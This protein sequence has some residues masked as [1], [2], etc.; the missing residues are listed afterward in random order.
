MATIGVGIIGAGQI[1][2]L[3]AK[4][5]LADERAQIRAVCDFKEHTAIE[6][7]MA[8][9]ADAYYTDHRALLEDRNVQLVDITTP[10]NLH[11][12]MVL[13]A[14][15]A[16]K[17]VLVQRPLALTVAEAD[18]LI[19]EAQK[20]G[21]VLAV[22][23]PN[24]QYGPLVDAKGYLDS[25]EIGDPISLRCKVGVGAPEGGWS[26][27]PE[28]W[29]WRFDAQRCGGGPF[30]FDGVYSTFATAFQL[31]GAVDMLQAW[32]GRTEIYPGYFVDAPATALWRHRWRGC[33]GS[34][35]LTY[36]PEMY[37]KSSHYPMDARVELTGTKGIL[38]VR[39]A[40]GNVLMGPPVQMYRDGRLFS[41]GEVDDGWESG[42]LAMARNTLDAVQNKAEL[43]F[44][45]DAAR[46]ILRMTLA[47]RDSSRSERPAK[48]GP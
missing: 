48:M 7:A 47:A 29:L 46:E 38:W 31:L 12:P 3:H 6:R 36:S 34:L 2:A 35:E 27:K 28:S 1:S 42:F 37:I 4:G 39:A 33:P 11:A 16:G 22:A 26:V 32:L 8:W 13:D 41:F 9:K 17:H 10:H 5:W 15:L 25:G 19:A 30:L 24:A 20:R 18:R 45:P 44:K 43:T 23:E 14:L 40:P 21:L